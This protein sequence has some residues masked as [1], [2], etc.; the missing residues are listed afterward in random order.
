MLTACSPDCGLP[1]LIGASEESPSGMVNSRQRHD[2]YPWS[3]HCRHQ[4]SLQLPKNIGQQQDYAHERLDGNF[5]KQSNPDSLLLLILPVCL[6]MT[7]LVSCCHV[8][9][10]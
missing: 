8:Q 1:S 3:H 6:S 7:S 10:I 9:Y 4:L 5:S 2:Q